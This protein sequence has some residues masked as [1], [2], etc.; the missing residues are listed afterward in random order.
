MLN[1]LHQLVANFVCLP[2]AAGQVVYSGFI[3]AFFYWKQLPAAAGNDAD[4]NGEREPKQLSYTLWN[5]KNE[6]K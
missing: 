6:L 3:R 2:F 5:Q 1:F 4:E